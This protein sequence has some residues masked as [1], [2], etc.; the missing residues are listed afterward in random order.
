MGPIRRLTRRLAPLALCAA[1]LAACAERGPS[2]APACAVPAGSWLDPA[3]GRTLGD[4]AVLG[5]AASA[6]IV[7]LGE[8]HDDVRHHRWHEQMLEAIHERRRPLVIG[9]ETLPRRAQPALD[10]WVAGSLGEAQFLDDVRWSETWGYDPALY[11]P[12]FRFARDHRIPMLA[13]NVDRS[14]VAKV[15]RSGWEAVP[16]GEREGVGEPAMPAEPYRRSLEAVFAE[17]AGSGAAADADSVRVERFTQAQVTWDRAM[18][19]AIAAAVASRPGAT[20]VGIAGRGHVEHGWGIG[21]Q[22]AD[23]GVARPVALL[24]VEADEACAAAPDLADA[25]FVLPKKVAAER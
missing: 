8:V 13:M 7:L 20:V 11:L 25:L 24:A 5:R 17:H 18:A 1:L 6:R 10:A 23:L 12:V 2:T 19:E 21:H 14:L 15:A 16:A 4:E 9:V 22:L 3:T